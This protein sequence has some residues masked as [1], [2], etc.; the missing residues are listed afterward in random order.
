MYNEMREALI[1]AAIREIH[2]TIEDVV[3]QVAKREIDPYTACERL[4]EAFK[5]GRDG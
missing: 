5:S 3:G 4:V 1:E 2:G